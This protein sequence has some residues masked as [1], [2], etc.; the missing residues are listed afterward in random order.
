MF[1]EVYDTNSKSIHTGEEPYIHDFIIVS[2]IKKQC[3]RI[4]NILVGINYFVHRKRLAL[5]LLLIQCLN[6]I[7][8][9]C[10]VKLILI[11]IKEQHLYFKLLS[12]LDI[13]ISGPHIFM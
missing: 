10:S 11:I 1:C 13:Q 9:F 4:S 6:H 7:C 2:F 3:T 8:S 5:K 12:I